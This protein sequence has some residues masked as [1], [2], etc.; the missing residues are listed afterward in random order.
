M[1]FIDQGCKP[2]RKRNDNKPLSV[3]KKAEFQ[4]GI[5]LGYLSQST[6]FSAAGHPSRC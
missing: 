3:L 6:F 4:E 1:A 5:F 2:L